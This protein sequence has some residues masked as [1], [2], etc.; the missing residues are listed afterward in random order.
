MSDLAFARKYRPTTI[1]GYIGNSDVKDKIMTALAKGKRPQVIMLEGN[2]GCGKTTIARLLAKEY[3]CEN[4]DPVNGACD[5]CATCKAVDNYIL[6][7]STDQIENIMEFNISDKSGKNDMDEFFDDIEIPAFEDE[8][9]VYILDEVQSASIGLQN[10]LL[11][12]TEEPPENT[13]IIFCTTNP[14]KILDTLK[15]RCQLKLHIQKPK[16]KELVSLLAGVCK[17]EGCAYDEKG[18]EF[19]AQ[20]ADRAIRTSLQYLQDVVTQ[21]DGAKYEDCIN[22]FQ[23][24]SESTLKDIFVKLKHHDTLGYVSLLNKVKQTVNFDEFIK[25]LK[26]FVVRGIYVRNGVVQEGISPAEFKMYGNLFN[27]LTEGQVVTLLNKLIEIGSGRNDVE[28]QLLLLGYSGLTDETVSSTVPTV[29]P[30]DKA[31]ELSAENTHIAQEVK[32]EKQEEF[33]EG[34]KHAEEMVKPVSTDDLLSWFGGAK[35]D[36]K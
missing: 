13:L 32:K 27:E 31:E 33:E 12:I 3:K 15:N 17:S 25:E 5:S 29:H 10:R 2:S 4:R 26:G 6:T 14:E 16:L 9:K 34:V 1:S 23:T 20:R 21:K 11:K 19:I 28:V 22:V 30:Q 35:V 7:G 24:V 36:N 18:L 8:W